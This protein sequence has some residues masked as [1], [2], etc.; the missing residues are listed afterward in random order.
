MPTTDEKERKREELKHTIRA[1][2]D[3]MPIIKGP[4]PP[5]TD[6]LLSQISKGSADSGD[7]IVK[8]YNDYFSKFP[9]LSNIINIITPPLT[10]EDQNYISSLKAKT[11]IGDNLIQEWSGLTSQWYQIPVIFPWCLPPALTI[12]KGKRGMKC[13]EWEKDSSKIALFLKRLFIGDLVWLF[14]YERM[15]IFKILGV[16]LDDFA[17]KGRY[18]FPNNIKEGTGIMEA[19]VRLTKMGL[20]STVRDRD[21]SYRRCLGWTS[22]VGRKLGI[23]AV[24]NTAF[25]TLFHKFIQT[26]LEY[27]KEKRLAT[28]IQLTATSS[29]QSVATLTAVRNTIEVL[30]QAFKPFDY[31]RNYSNTLSGIVWVIGSMAI[32]RDMR[33]RLGIADDYNEPHQYI[34]AA[35]D[36][37]VRGKQITPSESNRYTLHKEC[38]EYARDILLDIE[39]L[40]KT[41]ITE[42]EIWLDNVETKIEGY[43]ATYRNL[44]P[45]GVDLGMPPV[46]P[47]IPKIE[48]QV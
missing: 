42:I 13:L 9:E 17:T 7:D 46:P 34:P 1:K 27:Y 16:I 37:L 12:L 15:G 20:S 24:V 29:T 43:R 21:S 10:E 48:Q 23:D 2:L 33:T 3:G 19:M 40:D 5:C 31:G 36:L 32:I 35:Y 28:A 45:D 39:V 8:A 6:V 47:G 4:M 14:Y 38:A 11:H 25:N 22:D 26:A 18:P 41:N 30:Y 44:T